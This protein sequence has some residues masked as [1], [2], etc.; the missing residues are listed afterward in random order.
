MSDEKLDYAQQRWAKDFEELDRQIGEMALI[1][2]VQL[3]DPGVIERVLKND[4][5]VC[6]TDNP[7]AFEKMRSLLM[8]H[9]KM[10]DMAVVR[11]GEADTLRIQDEIIKRLRERFGDDLGVGAGGGEQG[12]GVGAHARAL[13]FHWRR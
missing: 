8:L 13:A 10:R 3:L 11:F 6:G 12:A 4:R 7:E 1:C 5:L 9:Y 2:Q